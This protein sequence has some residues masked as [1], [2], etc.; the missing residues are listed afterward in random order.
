M[1][2]RQS[3]SGDSRRGSATD[4]VD[5]L[6]I[7]D[8]RRRSPL[9]PLPQ[10]LTGCLKKADPRGGI[11][12]KPG[13]ASGGGRGSGGGGSGGGGGAPTAASAPSPRRK[14]RR[15]RKRLWSRRRR[16]YQ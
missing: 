16:R 7:R 4:F 2:C 12:A 11:G 15:P 13:G 3:P 1:I 10:D 14:R 8:T 5:R 9:N 6:L